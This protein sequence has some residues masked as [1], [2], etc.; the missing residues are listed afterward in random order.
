MFLRPPL[1]IP[2]AG[3]R[4]GKIPFTM[5]DDGNPWHDKLRACMYDSTNK[6]FILST[7]EGFYY[8]KDNFQTPLKTFASEPPVSVM[9]I[10]VFE[11][12]GR[13]GLLVGSF[14]GLYLWY[15]DH[16][17]IENAI[18]RKQHTETTGRGNPISENAIAGMIW[19]ST[20]KP[21]LFDYGKGAAAWLHDKTFADLPYHVRKNSPISLWNLSLEF[22][23][24]RI[25]GALIGDFYILIIPLAG[26]SILF[27]IILGFWMYL[28]AFKV[29]HRKK[30][31][32]SNLP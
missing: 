18:T 14:S 6:Q 22:H 16:G 4:V 11:P 17:Y 26:L 24:A 8:S 32:A 28:E 19:S 3:S 7:S 10:N 15:P 9:G 21:Y 25:Y 12:V 1:L 13:G 5:L 20:G 2:I 27:M 23:T 31:P 29:K 30:H